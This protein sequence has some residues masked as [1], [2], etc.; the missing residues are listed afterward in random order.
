MKFIEIGEQVAMI[1]FFVC[2]G[3]VKQIEGLSLDLILFLIRLSKLQQL[4]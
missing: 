2:V 1:V 3:N 4:V